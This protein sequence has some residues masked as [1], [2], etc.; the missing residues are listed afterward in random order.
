MDWYAWEKLS[1]NRGAFTYV[2]KKLILHRIHEGSTTSEM[3]N[4]DK[5]SMEDYEIFQL[6]WPKFVAKMLTKIYKNSE[7][8]NE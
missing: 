3:I 2:A 4:D 1:K 6:F 8:N 7:K 5:R